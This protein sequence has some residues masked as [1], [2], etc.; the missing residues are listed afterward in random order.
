MD[1]R[2]EAIFI[3]QTDALIVKMDQKK[4]P[5]VARLSREQIDFL[6][7]AGIKKSSREHDQ[8]RSSC[9]QS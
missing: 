5:A 8:G 4:S 7:R 6:K 1:K 2:Y 3:L 9:P